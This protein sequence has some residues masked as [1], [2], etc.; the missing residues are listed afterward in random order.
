[1]N[2]FIPKILTSKNVYEP[3]EDSYLLLENLIANKGD[4]CMD[5]GTGTGILAIA[6][7]KKG[8]KVI[9]TDV[10]EYALKL[11]KENA[12]LN[13]VENLIEFRKSDLFE[14]VQEKFDL[15]VFNCPYLPINDLGILEKA[16]SGGNFETIY[17]FF[18]EVDKH[19]NKG[20]KFEILIS[21]LTKINM[22]NFEKKYK[23]KKLASKKLFF[24]EIFV[25][26][27]EVL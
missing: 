3:A 7:A 13:G 16:W 12:L 20:G 15:I 6:L 18:N 14:A 1:M 8:C 17:K 23:L 25:M 19:L 22:K 27:G 2:L 5:I 4:F 26:V 21:S 9:A 24:E 11:A 10:N